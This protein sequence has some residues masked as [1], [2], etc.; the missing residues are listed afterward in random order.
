M[1]VL[2]RISGTTRESNKQVIFSI[3]EIIKKRI[4]QDQDSKKIKASGKSAGSMDIQEL[5]TGGQ[6]V[7]DDYFQQQI[8]GRKPGKFPPIKPIM[9]WIDQKGLSLTGITKKGLAFVIARKISEKGTDIF[10]KK[11]PG[12]DINSIVNDVRSQLVDQLIKAG[13]IELKT[14]F[15]KALKGIQAQNLKA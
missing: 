9:D 6:L 3:L 14:S 12:L 2:V 4:K 5:K 7:G 11:R 15:T 8:V 10:R 1:K 13:N